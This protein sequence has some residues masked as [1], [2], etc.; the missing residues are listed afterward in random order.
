MYM[1]AMA[2]GEQYRVPLCAFVLAEKKTTSS[3][4]RDEEEEEKKVSV[5]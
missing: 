3:Q 5:D 1:V 4:Q 2:L